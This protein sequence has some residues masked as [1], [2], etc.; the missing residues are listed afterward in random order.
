MR[1]DFM[2]SSVAKSFSAARY[3]GRVLLA[4]LCL[5]VASLPVSADW[6]EYSDDVSGVE[7]RVWA[8]DGGEKI[9]REVT[10]WDGATVKTFGARN[11]IVSFS[12]IVDNGGVPV[13]DLAVQFDVLQNNAEQYTLA[14]TDHAL[15]SMFDWRNRPIEVFVVEYLR[16][17]GL[18][19]ISYAF[20]DETHIPEHIR[21]PIPLN[22][23]PLAPAVGEGVWSDRPHHDLSYPD[24]AIPQE[25]ELVK[26]GVSLPTDQ[27]QIYWVDIYIPKD[28]PAGFLSGSLSVQV[29][30]TEL[31]SVPVEIEVY[32][33]ELPDE[34]A[35][36]TMVYIEARDVKER[37]FTGILQPLAGAD[38]QAFRDVINRHFMLAW[39]HGI[40]LF[41]ANE[42]LPDQVPDVEKPNIDWVDRLSGDLYTQANGYAGPGQ[43][44]PHDIYV[45]GSYGAWSFWW[46]LRQYHPLSPTFDSAA[47]L[48]DLQSALEDNTSLW[49]TWFQANAP[50]VTRF[51]YVED[52]P[53]SAATIAY[54]ELISGIV[55]NSP[56]AGSEL[57]TL[58]TANSVEHESTL[59]SPS[60]L[61]SIISVGDTEQWDRVLFENP[62]REQHMY[63]GQRPA[64]GSFATD[65]D[66]VALRELP[67]GQYK[68]DIDRWFY[69]HSTYYNNTQAGPSLRNLSE[70]AGG[71][72]E[73]YR[74]GSHT[75]V[76]KS[77]HTFGGHQAGFHPV[78][79]ETGFNYGNGDGLLFYPG[80]DVV[81]PDE[82]RSLNG[83]IASLR[84]K[85]WRRGI[86]DVQYL[87]MAAELDASGTQ[88]I[89][90]NMV[91][92][93]LWE[94]GVAD[95]ADPTY[96][97]KAPSWSN[98]PD[99]WELA[100]KA[101]AQIIQQDQT[102]I[103]P[104]ITLQP[105]DQTLN[106][107]D[108]LDLVVEVEG[109]PSPVVQWKKDGVEILDAVF[110]TLT[111][112]NT[113]LGD[114]G[115]YE[116][117]VSNTAGSVVS[118]SA[119]VVV[120]EA[121]VAPEIT[122]Q[123]E[124]TTAVVGETAS[125]TVVATGNP[126][127]DYQWLKDGA[128]IAGA[129]EATYSLPEVALDD[130]GQFSVLV[131]NTE[132]DVTSEA[133]ALTVDEASSAPEIIT[134]P[135]AVTATEGD[136]ASFSVVA[137][138]NPDPAYQWLK[139]G[140]AIAGATAATYSLPAV[141]LDDAGQFSVLVSN[142][143]GSVTSDAAELIVNEAL[144]APEIVSQP[145]AA[146]ATEGDAASFAVTATG[147]PDPAYQW[148]KDGAAIAGANQATYSLPAVTLDD[149]GQYSVIASNS[150]GS[151]TSEA[152][153]LGVN[154]PLS[155]P[156]ILTQP[157]AVNATEGDAASF[158]IA[159]TA[160]PDP[161]YQWLKDGTAIAGANEPTYSLSAVTLDDAGQYSVSLSNSE[162]SVT[163]NAAT[164]VV[165][166][167]L[168]APAFLS[169]PSGVNATEGDT[170][171]FTIAA[172][173]NPDP[174]YQWFKDGAAIAGATQATLSLPSVTLSD[175]GLYSA[176]AANSEA[177]V[178]SAAAALVVNEAL[179]AP[180]ILSQPQEVTGL[181]GQTITF[182]VEA[183]GNPA[184]QYQWLKDGVAVVGANLSSLKI[185]DAVL[186]DAGQYSVLVSNSDVPPQSNEA[187]VALIIG[188][189]N[190]PTSAD[191]AV[192]DALEAMG[193][194]VTLFDDHSVT[195]AATTGNDLVVLGGSVNPSLA[196]STFVADSRPVLVG[197]G[198]SF[199]PMDLTGPA[200]NVDYGQLA[201]NDEIAV[202]PA[203]SA[204]GATAG[205]LEVLTRNRRMGY[206]VPGAGAVVFASALNNVSQAT[207]FG[208][209]AGASLS[210]GSAAS[211]KRL[212]FFLSGF[213]S[214]FWTDDGIA[215]FEQ[216]IN[217]LLVSEPAAL[218]APVVVSGPADVAAPVGTEI[219]L[220][221]SVSG[222]P[223][224]N[225]QWF[226]DGSLLSGATTDELTLVA[227]VSTAGSYVLQASN[228]EGSVDTA[229]VVLSLIVDD[230][231]PEVVSVTAPTLTSLQVTLSEAIT[232]D[233]AIS[234]SNYALGGGAP[235]LAAEQIDS[236]NVLLTT[237]TLSPDSSDTLLVSDLSDAA[238]NLL[239]AVSESFITPAAPPESNEVAVA[240]VVAN[241]GN[242]TAADR[243][244]RDALESMG[245]SVTLFDDNSVTVAAT[246]GNNLVVLAGSVNPNVAGSLFAADSRPVLVGR[247]TSF[248]AMGLTGPGLNVDHGQLTTNDEITVLPAA[249]ALGATAGNLD[250][251]TRNRRM[252]YGVP[253]A[254]AVV[255][256]SGLG[257]ASRATV[258]GYEAGS[259]LSDGSPAFGKRLGYFLSGFLANFWTDG[260][261]A[262]FEQSVNWLLD[263]EPAAL[264]A[265]V[266]LSGP[267]DVAAAIGTEVTLSA[268]VSGNPVPVYQWFKDGSVMPGATTD[269][270]TLVAD[271]A[272]AGSYVLQASRRVCR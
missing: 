121:L 174:V 144:S 182:T 93:I 132:G 149:A 195:V 11:E 173:G 104:T 2:F 226:K 136:A 188:N 69:W 33:F 207:V 114:A 224:P 27:S 50:D 160:N 254:D 230:I 171:T 265:P 91:P 12:L 6:L 107:G 167:A 57:G 183:V 159:A 170:A 1:R 243:A 37:Y 196:G 103:A 54:A 92:S 128:A 268:T 242:P 155:S 102:E 125:F 219:T 39:R 153:A 235:V 238:G 135:S 184:P 141:S 223:T 23:Q 210:D 79:G 84:L 175:A 192:R 202:L 19:R 68:R 52:E 95:P 126:D 100:R 64:S 61:S 55:E 151:V 246:A 130:A 89:V 71:E 232:G 251:L 53:G 256:A 211:G 185:L 147:N 218:S 73:S 205:N 249:S 99:D 22:I 110:N 166:E 47:P 213:L 199:T 198:T 98:D 146:N 189:P 221:V 165:N 148:M 172:T 32:D 264:S 239:V 208:Y 85:H 177:S 180:V 90:N 204:L 227:G 118:Q 10:S 34:R 209:E 78:R 20:D 123:P 247:S 113:T 258:F 18:S 267:A 116:A 87:A 161:A 51:L 119:V 203:A 35:S 60:I 266:V 112:A 176:T 179:S 236:T 67:W 97:N 271:V 49:E 158:T 206:G 169:Q 255:F 94:P 44:V 250:V 240:L 215:L 217:W 253:G 263:S 81:F 21:R 63:N 30:S 66:G 101:L 220:S 124:S 163:S 137:T 41:D 187:A 200:L 229:A 115:S 201:T 16:I 142:S 25:V 76:F 82:N 83:P 152:V 74:L 24:I 262:L 241:P 231:A 13:D 86:Q 162:G 122:Q 4:L 36:K 216:S 139:D 120:N 43:D 134:Q 28:A 214:N 154:E 228:S 48:A 42:L 117:V 261:T 72:G 186:E 59:L 106:E 31:L 191:R 8:N 194:T 233:S 77:A 245:H 197:R 17:H 96:V 133:V 140:A 259:A 222:N 75:N 138:G 234:L 108:A 272:T 80:T 15:T 127:P 131:S 109:T 7:I 5:F 45:V 70:V 65:D 244:V 252:G 248:A 38:E 129:T 164:L 225:Y 168:S 257:D 26:G 270:L 190:N 9:P 150:E 156:E 3:C 58:V 62:D 56:L 29:D 88:A 46:D 157:S 178:E 193:H 111:I 212:G 269:Q 260:G 181:V 145:L 143:E 105:L 40:S 14:T 237:G